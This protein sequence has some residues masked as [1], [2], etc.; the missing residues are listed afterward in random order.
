[1]TPIGDLLPFHVPS[2]TRPT[3]TEHEFPQV[4]GSNL[5]REEVV[6]P[7]DL[8]GAVNLLLIAFQRHH[9][10]WIDQWLPLAKRLEAD[11]QGLA[12]YEL[13]T[14]DSYNAPSR[15]WINEGMRAGIPDPVARERTITLF[16]EN[17]EEFLRALD[18]ESQET[19]HALLVTR[20]GEILWRAEGLPT[21]EAVDSLLARLEAR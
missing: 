5:E 4:T 12:Y 8:V 3:A 16:L 2:T 15:M 11:G 17:K 6:L 14:L 21:D 9:Q 19:I 7:R 10:D 18:I 13:P 1:M 20:E